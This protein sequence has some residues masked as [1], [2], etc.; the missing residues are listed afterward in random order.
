MY[1]FSVKQWNPFSGCEHECKYCVSSFQRQLKRWAKKN[2]QGCYKFE[3]HEH[4]ERLSQ[5]LPTTNYMQYIFTCSNGDI[6]FCETDYLKKIIKRIKKEPNK[7]FLIQSKD[8]K[9]FKRVAFP[10]NVILGTTIESNK[11]DLVEAVSKAPKPSERYN[12]FLEVNHP[13]K[14]ITIEPVI[15]F[16]LD[17]MISWVIEIK[18]C[19]VWLGYDS[20][21]NNLVEPE[22]EKVLQLY[23]ELGKRDFL[24]K[25]KTV[26]EKR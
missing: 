24:V 23:W 12:D 15:D 17:I 9:T 6:A 25:L 4:P 1:E 2:C 26:R 22:L 13:T 3:P 8:P 21:K 20:K 11:D 18:P 16:D 10:R 7:T 5:S 19:M 14:M